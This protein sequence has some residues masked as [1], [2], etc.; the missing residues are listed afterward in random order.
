[1]ILGLTG[2]SNPKPEYKKPVFNANSKHIIMR[3]NEYFLIPYGATATPRVYTNSEKDLEK[4][5]FYKKNGLHCK[6]GD[7]FWVENSKVALTTDIY[8]NN[9]KTGV[10][11]YAISLWKKGKANC[12]SP[13]TDKEYQFYRSQEIE[14]R[15]ETI[16]AN[17]AYRNATIAT[18]NAYLLNRSSR[19]INVNLQGSINHN[20][21]YGY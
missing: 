3:N 6:I 18:M 20:I 2:C 10:R 4:V 7:I 15:R 19:K 11:K 12:A 13:L 8:K 17:E 5:N 14:D 1:M 16:A 21:R 9:G